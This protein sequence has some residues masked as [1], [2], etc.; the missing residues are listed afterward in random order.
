MTLR[1][2]T[3]LIIGV[4]LVGLIVI[5]YGTASTIVLNS[6]NNLEAQTTRRNVERAVNALQDSL[7][8]LEL[9]TKDYAEWDDTY[10]YIVEPNAGYIDNNFFDQ[11]MVDLDINLVLLINNAGET[12]F[13]KAFDLE[14]QQEIPFSPDLEDYMAANWDQLLQFA[15]SQGGQKGIVLLADGPI[16]ISANPILTSLDQGPSRGVLI[17]GR[18]LNQA[19]VEELA[20][21][22]NLEISL[23]RLDGALPGDFQAAFEHLSPTESLFIQPLEAETVAGYALL[24]DLYEQ[25][26]LLLRITVARSIY[27][28][29]QR[30]LRY[31]LFSLLATGLVFGLVTTALLE[32]SVLSR[33]TRLSAWVSRVGREGDLAY[34]VE[35]TGQDELAQLAEDINSML[36][37]LEFTQQE[38][39]EAKKAAEAASQA[40]SSFLANMSHELRTPLSAIIGY[41]ELLLEDIER[42]TLPELTA[43]LQRI[44]TSG[45]H[46]LALINDILDLSKIEAGKMKLDI[47]NFDVSNVVDEIISTVEPLIT[48]NHNTLEVHLPSERISMQADIGKLRQCLLNLLSNAAKFTE[49]GRITLTVTLEPASTQEDG[50]APQPGDWLVLKVT[51]TGIG[52][53]PE[54]LRK[55]FQPFTQADNSTSRKYGGTGLGLVISR[56]FCQMMGGDIAATSPGI[57]GQ[58]STF[59]MRLPL[60]AR[61]KETMAGKDRPQTVVTTSIVS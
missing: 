46:L 15:E 44:R 45:Q 10:N 26:A 17:M 54:Q 24:S 25:P 32:K 20:E 56:H 14:T 34:R 23:E 58:G 42:L 40:K 57:P 3:L 18:F 19:K 13:G 27:A 5:L 28:Q 6:F 53:A 30:A 9:T 33:L 2:K 12:I 49:N 47:S 61:E 4:T 31:F 52:I 8:T 38:L 35:I 50:A 51:D 43:D 21:L 29:G 37:A 60:I 41:S 11:N 16:L 7:T 59:T 36:T 1:K 55:L 39:Q 48:K 22:T